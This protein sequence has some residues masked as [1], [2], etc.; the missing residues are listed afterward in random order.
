[1][2]AKARKMYLSAEPNS[3]SELRESSAGIWKKYL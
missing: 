2:D 1:M 3:L